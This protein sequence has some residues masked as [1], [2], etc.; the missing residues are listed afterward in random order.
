[1]KWPHRCTCRKAIAIIVGLGSAAAL[2]PAQS[3]VFDETQLPVPR[4]CSAS[5]PT[6]NYDAGQVVLT[7]QLSGGGQT[8]SITWTDGEIRR[9]GGFGDE[10]GSGFIRH[11]ASDIKR[12]VGDGSPWRLQIA[13]GTNASERI[14]GCERLGGMTRAFLLTPLKE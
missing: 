13:R 4:A 2:A 5:P 1:M 12:R 7:C 3:V 10:F 6:A 14:V 11:E 8:R 9:L